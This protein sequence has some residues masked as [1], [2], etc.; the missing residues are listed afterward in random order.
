MLEKTLRKAG[1]DALLARVNAAGG[2]D[3]KA[4]KT[5][6][7]VTA[8]SYGGLVA[9]RSSAV[10]FAAPIVASARMKVRSTP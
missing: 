1:A 7:N 9:G 4:S 8:G 10:R 3:P 6:F 5:A 2:V